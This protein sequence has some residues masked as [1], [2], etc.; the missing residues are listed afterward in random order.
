MSQEEQFLQE[1]RRQRIAQIRQL[2]DQIETLVKDLT[3]EQLTTHFL[4][5]EWTVAQNVHHLVDSHMNSYIRCKLMATEDQPPL[6]P[7]DQDAWA[8]HA[9]AT[10][11]DIQNSLI[12]LRALHERW[13]QFWE[14]LPDSAWARTGMRPTAGPISLN[15]QLGLY[16]EHGLAHIDQI[17]RT[18]EAQ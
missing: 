5:D 12:M 16:V 11:A 2:P 9:D 4:A 10:T 18:L 7:Y 15:D 3:V 6:K 8:M 13:A 17:E 14:S 1:I